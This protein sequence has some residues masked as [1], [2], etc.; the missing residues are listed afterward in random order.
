[1]SAFS[2]FGAT[3]SISVHRDST[4]THGSSEFALLL[5]AAAVLL[6]CLRHTAACVSAS[7]DST[8]EGVPDDLIRGSCG[9]RGP[10]NVD[11]LFQCERGQYSCTLLIH[12]PSSAHSSLNDTDFFSDGFL[13]DPEGGAGL[14]VCLVIGSIVLYDGRTQ[15]QVVG[16]IFFWVVLGIWTGIYNMSNK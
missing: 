13:V 6:Y 4:S 2:N 3:S 5:L 9:R 12:V 16:H 11:I 10:W 7:V 14:S 1:M 15:L 8:E